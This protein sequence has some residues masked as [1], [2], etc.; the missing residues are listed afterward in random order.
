MMTWPPSSS[1]DPGAPRVQDVRGSLDA[2]RV[3]AAWNAPSGEEQP[4]QEK[5][6]DHAICGTVPG[7]VPVP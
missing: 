5:G 3:A 4:G 6:G 2:V 1:P 7:G